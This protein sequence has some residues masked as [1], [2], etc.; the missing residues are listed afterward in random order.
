MS[1]ESWTPDDS[2]PVWKEQT[3]PQ[4]PHEYCF[5]VGEGSTFKEIGNLC[6]LQENNGEKMGSTYCNKNIYTVYFKHCWHWEGTKTKENLE[7]Q[8][9]F[10]TVQRFNRCR[11]IEQETVFVHYLD[12]QGQASTTLVDI[13][14][15]ECVTA[16]GICSCNYNQLGDLDSWR[17]DTEKKSKS[18]AISMKL[19]SW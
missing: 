10:F 18:G 15:L 12:K 4:S 19:V 1:W 2:F 17:R 11:I 3:P 13:A 8:G 14:S 9:F 7:K 16:E 6:D 5:F